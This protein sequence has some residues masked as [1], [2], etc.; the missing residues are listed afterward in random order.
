MPKKVLCLVTGG[1]GFIGSH[2][3]EAL[4]KRGY[5]VRVLDNLSTGRAANLASMRGELVFQKGD[6]RD[7]RAVRR[8][9]RSVDYVFHFAACR[10]V[11]Q[12]VDHPYE[13]NDVNV[14]GTLKLLL[15]ARDAKVRRFISSSSSS[16]YGDSKKYPVK[17][18]DTPDPLSPYAA[19]KIA[20]E[21][22]GR[23]FHRLF[24]LETVCLRYFN[25][26]GPRQSPQSKYAAVI[27]IFI[28]ALRKGRS[29]VI[30]GDGLQSRDFT[31][32][33]NVVH[34]NLLAMKARG[35]G[36]EVFNIACHEEY[37]VL[38]LFRDLKKI[39]KVKGVEPKFARTRAGDIHRS[40]ADISKAR[41]LLGFKPQTRF[42]EGL[43][44]TVAWFLNNKS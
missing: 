34:A 38:D 3:V 24:G 9:M 41:R 44:K 37:P 10:A 29:P 27:P 23:I 21:Y 12:S 1:A 25:V 31:Y 36:G 39:L 33:G 20:G 13:T 15:A 8:A 35:V 17:E 22:Y 16:V 43:Q 11:L 19:S 40:F 42:F 14:N 18:T 4:L 6:I 2:M 7:D 5:R 28:D 26:F 30:F 32:V